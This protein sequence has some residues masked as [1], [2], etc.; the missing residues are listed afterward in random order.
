[1]FIL[2]I[3]SYFFNL[4]LESFDLISFNFYIVFLFFHD[5]YEMKFFL[6]TQNFP[7]FLVITLELDS[8]GFFLHS[9]KL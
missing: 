9:L 2:I 5:I 6:E 7:S 8:S 4:D 3:F 1:M